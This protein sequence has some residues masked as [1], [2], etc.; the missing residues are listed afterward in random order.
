MRLL[1]KKGVKWEWTEDRDTDFNNLKKELTTQPCLAHYNGN[2]ESIVTTDA[3]NTGLRIAL[4]QRQNN[5]ELKAI[6]YARRYLNDAEKK[7]RRRT[8]IVSRSLG[9][10]TVQIPPIRETGPNIFGSPSHGTAT[11]EK[12]YQ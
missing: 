8:R 11:E 7:F 6:A 4:W 3:C 12:Q 10:R 5:G 1:L 9:P 2:R